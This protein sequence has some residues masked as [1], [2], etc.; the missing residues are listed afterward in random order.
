[1]KHITVEQLHELDN[2]NYAWFAIKFM[3]HRNY[4]NPESMDN[5]VSKACTPKRMKE[6]LRKHE[7]VSFEES[8]DIYV[9]WEKVKQTV[10]QLNK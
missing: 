2:Y 7:V 3:G 8:D 10:K 5:Q 4:R 1:M 9:I 6:F